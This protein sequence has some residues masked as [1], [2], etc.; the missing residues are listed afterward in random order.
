MTT[1]CNN[2]NSR[3]CDLATDLLLKNYHRRSK[4]IFY[5]KVPQH[6]TGPLDCF[7][8]E[9]SCPHRPYRYRT[10]PRICAMTPFFH[11][12]AKKCNI[13]SMGLQISYHGSMGAMLARIKSGYSRALRGYT[14]YGRLRNL[15]TYN[16]HIFP[17]AKAGNFHHFAPLSSKLCHFLPHSPRGGYTLY[18]ARQARDSRLLGHKGQQYHRVSHRR[19]VIS[20]ERRPI[21]NSATIWKFPPQAPSN[22]LEYYKGKLLLLQI[23]WNTCSIVNIVL[24]RWESW[25]FYVTLRPHT[26][27]SRARWVYSTAYPFLMDRDFVSHKFVPR[28]YLGLVVEISKLLPNLLLDVAR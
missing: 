22:L 18:W 21:T 9:I 3:W 11:Q 19:A 12:N 6:P 27:E 20:T 17:Q 25:R 1:G 26:W 10:D 4:I 2:K 8:I 28:R 7:S 13:F 5:I 23:R 24:L 14:V 16:F 15:Y